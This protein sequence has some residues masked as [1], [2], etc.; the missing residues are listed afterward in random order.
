MGRF[1]FSEIFQENPDG[2]LSPKNRIIVNGITIGPQAHFRPGVKFA[3]I[4]FFKYRHMDI[5]AEAQAPDLYEIKG[6]YK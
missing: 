3:G 5:A 4:D 1:Q 6:F 2:T